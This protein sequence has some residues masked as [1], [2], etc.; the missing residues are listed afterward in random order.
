MSI[1]LMGWLSV[2]TILTLSF[3]PARYA[4]SSRV[5]RLEI[6]VMPPSDRVEPAVKIKARRQ[7]A[8]GFWR[9][10]STVINRRAGT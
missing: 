10:T 6:V 9:M 1:T 2:I 8:A 4:F 3:L 7:A 5:R